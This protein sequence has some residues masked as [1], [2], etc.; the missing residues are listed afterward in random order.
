MSTRFIDRKL[1]DYTKGEELFNMISHIVGA[2]FGLFALIIC[3]AIS[4]YHR[5]IIGIVASSIYGISMILLYTMS[6][7]YHG[8]THPFA[9]RLFQVFDHCAIYFLIAGTYTPVALV[10]IRPNYPS[11]GWLIFGLQWGLAAIATALTAID[12]KRFKVIS[13]ICY[14]F[15]GWMIILFYPIILPSLGQSG[16][17]YMLVGGILYTIGAVLYGIGKRKRYMHNVFHVF[18]L[19]GSI[20]QFFGIILYVL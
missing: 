8:L 14:I 6:S 11:W 5:D 16:F 13:M 20:V 2:A 17:V 3:V 4:G 19:L 7:I 18:V 1:P 10:A 12:L 15:M 9:K